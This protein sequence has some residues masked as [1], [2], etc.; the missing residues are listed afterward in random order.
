MTLSKKDFDTKGLDTQWIESCK[1]IKVSLHL[2]PLLSCRIKINNFSRNA[3]IAASSADF[4]PLM[5]F[6]IDFRITKQT[7]RQSSGK[8]KF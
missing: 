7:L 6:D 4:I 3:W 1:L 8:L 5:I 2:S